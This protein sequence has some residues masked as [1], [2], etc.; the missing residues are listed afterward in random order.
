MTSDSLTGVHYTIVFN[1][2][3]FL[4][5]FNEINSRKVDLQKNVF[6]GIFTNVIFVGVILVTC[7]VQIIIVEVGGQAI[8]YALASRSLI[9]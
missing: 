1:T 3:V 6:A 5:V 2:F 8:R 7:V 9:H 4:Q